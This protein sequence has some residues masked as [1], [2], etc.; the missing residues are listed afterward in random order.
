MIIDVRYVL[1]QCSYEVFLKNARNVTKCMSS[2]HSRLSISFAL[3]SDKDLNKSYPI[4]KALRGIQQFLKENIQI[5]LDFSELFSSRILNLDVA[6]W[7]SKQHFNFSIGPYKLSEQY[8]QLRLS[9]LHTFILNAVTIQNT[10][11]WITHMR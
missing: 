7:K 1:I 4:F 11:I 3:P 9:Y 2:Q 8:L 10:V 6:F 5:R